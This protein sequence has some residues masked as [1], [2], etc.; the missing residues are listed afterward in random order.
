[1][2]CSV[3]NLLF[4]NI[5]T[6]PALLAVN[7]LHSRF[8]CNHT[9]KLQWF[10]HVFIWDHHQVHENECFCLLSLAC[11]QCE[12]GG[13]CCERKTNENMKNKTKWLKCGHKVQH[14]VSY[15]GH[16]MVNLHG[17]LLYF[18][19]SR[20]NFG[21][22][23]CLSHY[24]TFRVCVNKRRQDWSLFSSSVSDVAVDQSWSCT[25]QSLLG[26]LFVS[27]QCN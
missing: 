7:C 22:Y 9:C 5:H 15:H 11:W 21:K 18:V 26:S 25:I 2:L 16:V 12:G 24:L 27:D 1:M 4:S 8:M 6:R 10:C 14:D 19:N 17:K 13:E 23:I 3:C 20:L